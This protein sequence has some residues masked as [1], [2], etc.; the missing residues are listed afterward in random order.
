[1]VFTLSLF[2]SIPRLVTA[3][4]FLLLS[5]VVTAQNYSSDREEKI[6]TAKESM[7]LDR[8]S[9]IALF[10]LVT[11]QDDGQPIVDSLSGVAYHNLG[12][13][14]FRAGQDSLA[15]DFYQRAID[16][17]DSVFRRPHHE[18]AH[19]RTNLSACL[20]YTG[21][22]KLALRTAREA[23]LIY[24][25]LPEP[26]TG[27]WIA[28]LL[29][30]AEMALVLQDQQLARSASY[31]AISM[32]E[33]ID[34][35]ESRRYQAYYIAANVFLQFDALEEALLYARRSLHYAKVLDDPGRIINAY[36][37]VAI[38]EHKMGEASS[39]HDHLLS[40]IAVS[41][42]SNG[43]PAELASL[44]INLSDYYGTRADYGNSNK[45]DRLARRLF[46][47]SDELE[48]YAANVHHPLH[49]Q[50]MG[51]RREALELVGE[52][53]AVLAADTS[54]I[55]PLQW[56]RQHPAAIIPC[57]DLLSVRGAFLAAAGRDREALRDYVSAMELQDYLRTEVNSFDSRS[58]LS[59]N[60]RPLFDKI[61]ALYYA[62][63][64]KEN[65]R[66]YL[67]RAFEVSERARA[68]HL[69]AQVQ[70]SGVTNRRAVTKVDAEIARLERELAR[71][72]TGTKEKLATA[73]LQLDVLTR[74]E[75]TSQAKVFRLN[76][77]TLIAYLAAQGH[78]LIE[79]NLGKELGL[80]FVLTPGGDLTAFEI[81]DV[82][83]L[84]E[85]ITSWRSSIEEG[86]YR[87]KSLRPG[88]LQDSLDG[89]FV[90]EGA[91]LAREL[92]PKL[93]S[94]HPR[95]RLLI[96][97]DGGLHYLPFAALPIKSPH[98]RPLDYSKVTYLQD[99]V[100]LSHGYSAAVLLE[101][102]AQGQREYVRRLV[103]FAP[104]FAPGAVNGLT[105][106]AH[107]LRE[108]AGLQKMLPDAVTYTGAEATRAS[109][110]L[111]LGKAAILHLSS[112]GRVHPRDPQ[113]SFVSFSQLGDE[114]D[115]DQLLYFN[116]LRYLP[117]NNELT[118]L[119][120]CQ[121][122]LGELAIG[123]TT[124]SFGSALAAAGART[125][126]T[127]LW[128]VDDGAT[129]EL[130]LDFYHRLFR[131]T[132]RAC[133]LNEARSQLRQKGDFQHPYYWSGV[134]LYG[135]PSALPDSVLAGSRDAVEFIRISA[136]AILA[137]I[138][139]GTFCYFCWR[140]LN[141]ST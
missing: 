120:A 4:L 22:S 97:P 82:A 76:R 107:N 30:M 44:Y 39:E 24:E 117:V 131:G 127:T 115:E 50:E 75:Y 93:N 103:A 101:V 41:K 54:L 91:A 51:H 27:K 11:R 85:R 133:S 84:N 35:A 23:T 69:L 106:L 61:I 116:D 8:E 125:T 1:M 36:N 89:R 74:H 128:E 26:D 102:A 139:G 113:L 135:N 88:A 118:V 31:Q 132:S 129:K 96:I 48:I 37:Q 47:A 77:D 119:S 25:A 90:S 6:A 71:G 29:T 55:D 40:A 98:A 46:T 79:Y 59:K 111:E 5:T 110:D 70:S 38:T 9:A 66:E 21:Q 45:Y 140:R 86:R 87:R 57:I 2:M 17:R 81:D 134:V 60:L 112:H 49:L 104:D 52:K 28:S 64:L 141:V 92:L 67:W 138:L 58:Y 130:L 19:S 114:L 136:L 72:Y 63:Y 14:A 78:T 42:V 7:N 83:G 100:E 99:R 34:R 62:A 12:V 123:E 33:R 121:T 43:R 10:S 124:L 68:F 95:P 13:L 80:A 73:R 65:D 3:L 137:G 18:R 15:A 56:A 53:L 32:A 126:V 108:V 16:V 94:L 109:F 122:S 20:S 105:P